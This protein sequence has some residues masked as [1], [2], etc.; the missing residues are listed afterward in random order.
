MVLLTSLD[1][2]LLDRDIHRSVRY[3]KPVCGTVL[4]TV[5]HGNNPISR[6]SFHFGEA[7]TGLFQ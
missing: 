2:D 4:G 3:G 7:L 1:E 6:A 5:N